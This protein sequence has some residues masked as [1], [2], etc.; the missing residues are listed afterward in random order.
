MNPLHLPIWYSDY[1]NFIEKS[2][3]NYLSRYLA[4]PMTEPLEQ[5]K[6]IVKYSCKWGKKLRGILALEF[7]LQLT[8]KKFEEVRMDDDI[9]RVCIAL[10]IVHAFSLVHDDLPCMDNDE[11]RR[12]ELTVWK[13]YGEYNAVLVWDMLNSLC[14]EII[15]DIKDPLKSQKISKLIS[16]AI[17][18]YGMVWGQIEDLYY[19]EYIGDLDAEILRGLHA[20]KTWKLIEAS[21]LSW[22]ILSWET[23]NIDIYWDFWKKLWLAFQVKDDLLDVEWTPEETGKSVGWEEKGFVYLLGV[24]ATRKILSDIISECHTIAWS[25]SSEKIDFIVEFVEKRKK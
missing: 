21:I 25:L 16:H 2:L 17:G 24:D 6:E 18:F 5:F 4:I 14:F 7:Y 9:M 19:E 15:S 22:V 8:D 23:S 20:K 1:K 11:L 3:E 10:E 12:G 13:K